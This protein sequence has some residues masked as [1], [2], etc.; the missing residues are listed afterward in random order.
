MSSHPAVYSYILKFS[1]LVRNVAKLFSC[2]IFSIILFEKQNI[3][4]PSCIAVIQSS[5]GIKEHVGWETW[6]EHK[7]IFWICRKKSAQNFSDEY[8][9]FSKILFARQRILFYLCKNRQRNL[10]GP[11]IFK[12]EIF[13]NLLP[14]LSC[15]RTVLSFI[16][17]IPEI[18]LL[19][20]ESST[21]KRLPIFS[22][23]VRHPRGA[24]LHHNFVCAVLNDVFGI[25][26][27]GGHVCAGPYTFDLLGIDEK[28]AESYEKILSKNRWVYK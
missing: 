6:N 5:F 15:C 13:I 27:R 18:S 23:L 17:T 8:L 20:Y 11:M 9:D 16:R 26:A 21:V 14:F 7:T 2:N 19:G 24:F 10:I 3:I 22:F 4:K 28:L 1:K 25:Q 12:C